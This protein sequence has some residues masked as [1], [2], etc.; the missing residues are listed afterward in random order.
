MSGYALAVVPFPKRSDWEPWLTKQQVAQRLGLTPRSINN[1]MN[2]GMPHVHV[3]GRPRFKWS[4]VEAWL[5]DNKNEDS[6]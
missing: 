3:G 6:S 4:E 5:Q 2:D 1:R